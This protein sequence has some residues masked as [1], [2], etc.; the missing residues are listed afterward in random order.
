EGKGAQRADDAVQHQ[1][2]EHGALVVGGHQDER[3]VAG[4]GAQ[5]YGRTRLV[6]EGK[7]ERHLGAETLVESDVAQ[8][9]GA[10][11]LGARG[12][13]APGHGGEERSGREKSPHRLPPPRRCASRLMAR[14]IGMWTVP[15][16]RS[17]QPYPSSC[18]RSLA[19]RPSRSACGLVW[20]RGC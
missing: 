5:G 6:T 19:R 15:A 12:E 11:R 14:S 8:D 9:R 10:R 20:S 7:I 3:L 13:S 18:A 1:R 16:S 2:A 4:V 17:T